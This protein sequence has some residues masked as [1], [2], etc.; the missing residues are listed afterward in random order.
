ME[1]GIAEST[2]TIKTLSVNGK[3]M[4]KGI[5]SQLPRRSLL[6]DG[7]C[8]ME[9]RPWGYVVDQKCCHSAR[10]NPH[11]HVVHEYEGQL[12]VWVAAKRLQD[13]PWHLR[14]DVYVPRSKAGTA[15]LDAC[16]LET[17]LGCTDFFQGKVFSL[18]PEGELTT[19]IEGIKV[20]LSCSNEANRLRAAKERW[21]GHTSVEEAEKELRALYERRGKGA[22]ELYPE[23]VA[24]VALAKQ[25]R[26]NYAAA[27]QML[28]ELPQLFLGA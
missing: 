28:A 5:Y 20:C 26:A 10:H 8:A 9:G 24:D 22:R 11:W 25:A 12:F 23:L 7:D 3:R 27:L 2:V 15:F 14:D 18:V 16:L 19:T 17:H 1:L 4:S 21:P 6:A 13:A